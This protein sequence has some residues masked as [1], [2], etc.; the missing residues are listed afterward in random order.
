MEWKKQDVISRDLLLISKCLLDILE[1]LADAVG[2]F[3]MSKI[4]IGAGSRL[5]VRINV[6]G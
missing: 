2:R 5:C 4:A 3:L 1:V 6:R